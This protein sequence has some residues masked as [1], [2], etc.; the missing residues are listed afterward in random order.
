[1]LV[2]RFLKSN[3]ILYIFT[4]L[5]IYTGLAMEHRIRVMNEHDRRTLEWLRMKVG[6]VALESAAQ[7]IGVRTKPYVSAV[8]RELGVRPPQFATAR[9]VEGT[10]TGNQSIA[11]I[12]AL[13]ASKAASPQVRVHRGPNLR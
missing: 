13:L 4:L 1:M 10:P 12:K 5:F 6:D 11:A 8:C 2:I 7:R 3:K 9:R